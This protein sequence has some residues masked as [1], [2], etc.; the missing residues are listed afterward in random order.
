MLQVW[1]RSKLCPQHDG[2]M[3]MPLIHL[4]PLRIMELN[5]IMESMDKIAAGMIQCSKISLPIMESMDKI[6]AGM[7]QCSKISSST[8]HGHLV[9]PPTT[10]AGIGKKPWGQHP[11]HSGFAAEPFC[12]RRSFS[13]ALPH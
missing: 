1:D 7:I 10:A 2:L 13:A 11:V 12:E 5:I 8:N 3:F 6:A 4:Y 9:S